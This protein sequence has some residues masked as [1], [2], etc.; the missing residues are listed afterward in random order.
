MTSR[1]PDP[2]LA[3]FRVEPARETAHVLVE[4]RQ[5]HGLHQEWIVVRPRVVPERH[6]VPKHPGKQ[7]RVL[8]EISHEPCPIPRCE[9]CES[10]PIDE[11]RSGLDRIESE[12]GARERALAGANGPGDAD[13]R[14]RGDVEVECVQRRTFSARVP[15]RHIAQRYGDRPGSPSPGAGGASRNP[16]NMS[17]SKGSQ[18]RLAGHPQC[19]REQRP[20]PRICGGAA[21]H[22][23][24]ELRNPMAPVDEAEKQLEIGDEGAHRHHTGHDPL[25]ALP[26]DHDDAG[27]HHGRVNRLQAALQTREA[28][29]PLGHG[30]RPIGDALDRRGRPAE[31][32]QDPDRRK[33][34]LDRRGQMS[35]RLARPRGPARDPPARGVREDHREGDGQERDDRETRIDDEHGHDEG[36][37]EEDRVPDLDRELTDPDAKHLDV[38]DDPGHEIADRGRPQIGHRPR[39]NTAE[40]VGAHVRA[41]PRVRGHEPPALRDPGP[42]GQQRASDE[43]HGGPRDLSRRARASFQRECG[44]DRATE[45]NRGQDDGRVHDDARQRAET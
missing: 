13:E 16:G 25:A 41:D 21:L 1:D 30:P 23:V 15:E 3:D 35:A 26:D 32:A 40:G 27:D 17:R 7:E 44:V 20:E 6:V 10:M 45:E 9:I 42:F 2:E 11:D 33:L 29:V 39:E 38:A 43:Q 18:A 28:Q 37:R 22:G 34:F 8:R 24:H 31:E 36:E 12:N 5:P 14:S 19:W 4:G